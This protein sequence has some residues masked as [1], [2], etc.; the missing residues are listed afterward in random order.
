MECIWGS[1]IL[2]G[3]VEVGGAGPRRHEP[4]RETNAPSVCSSA[5]GDFA[6]EC[7]AYERAAALAARLTGPLPQPVFVLGARWEMCSGLDEGPLSRQGV[8]PSHENG[9]GSGTCQS[10]QSSSGS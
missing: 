7:V 3:P 6:A 10:F 8:G 5:L 1:R 9:V 2:V 4:G